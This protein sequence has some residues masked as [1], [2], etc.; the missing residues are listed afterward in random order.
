MQLFPY[1]PEDA[2][3]AAMAIFEALKEYNSERG[4]FP[5]IAVGLGIASG[6]VLIGTVG[7]SN[8]LVSPLVKLEITNF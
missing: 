1:Q 4:E 6:P 8:R 7:V 2:L 3:S 5:P